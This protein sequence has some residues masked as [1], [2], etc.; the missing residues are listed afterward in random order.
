MNETNLYPII[1]EGELLP[2]EEPLID[3]TKHH[4]VITPGDYFLTAP[5]K[6]KPFIVAGMIPESAITALTASSGAGKSVF[7]LILVK[8]VAMGEKL[9]N[10]FE[11]KQ[12]SVLILDLEM[13][14]DIISGRYKAFIDCPAP[15]YY[16]HNQSF[17][18]CDDEDF[19]WLAQQVLSKNIGLVIFD[20]IS[21]IFS[22]DENS[23][24]EMKEVNKKLLDLIRLSKTTILYLHHHRKKMA[25]ENNSQGSARGSTEI[26]AKVASHLLLDSKKEV[27]ETGNSVLKM[28]IEQ[29]KSRRPDGINKIGLNIMY[30]SETKKSTYEYL[31]EIDEKSQS[32][33]TA[34]EFLGSFMQLGTEY[35]IED[36]FLEKKKQG[37]IFGKNIIRN[38]CKELADE[39]ILDSH[40]GAGKEWNKSYYFKTF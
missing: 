17:D 21:N 25:G 30:N 27:D 23:A 33:G 8:H 12:S 16:I 15:I 37:L 1:P 34:K 4:L 22:Q 24:K 13:D 29:F 39:S 11:V 2:G 20:T 5:I 3:D 14:E 9:F 32:M 19:F 40:K 7:M 26:I 31:G 18:I 35:T 10:T 36:L 28:T 6:E 38:A